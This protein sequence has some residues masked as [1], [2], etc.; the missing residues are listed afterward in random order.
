MGEQAITKHGDRRGGE[1]KALRA[2]SAVFQTNNTQCAE[3]PEDETTDY[4][5][6]GDAWTSLLNPLIAPARFANEMRREREAASAREKERERETGRE[7]ITNIS[8]IK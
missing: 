2:H 1:G 4:V 3:A 5:L 7:R 8:I 6:S